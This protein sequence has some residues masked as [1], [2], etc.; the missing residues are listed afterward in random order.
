ML[1]AAVLQVNK[2]QA[3]IVSL[4]Y[5]QQQKPMVQVSLNYPFILS[6]YSPF[7]FMVGVDY[8]TKNKAVPS[9]F[10]PQTTLHYYLVDSK[11]YNYLLAVGAGAGYMFD[12]NSNHENQIR[13]SP[14]L[15]LEYSAILNLRVGYDV[16]FPNNRG[17][18]FISI[19]IGGLHGF[20]H[21]KW[22]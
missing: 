11:R 4:G 18:P 6:A 12:F 14:H 22:M 20:R 10:V 3:Q 15:Y 17:Y 1:I 13:I 16:M 2:S 8:T 7:E 9:G 19:G 21:M 5:K